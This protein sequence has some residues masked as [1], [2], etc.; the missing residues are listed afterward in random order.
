MEFQ[1]V[2]VEE[3][4]IVLPTYPAAKTE[5]LPMF[6]EFRSHQN[7]SGNPY[8]SH[9]AN[10]LERS[11]KKDRAWRLI[12]LENRYLRL[13]IMPELGGR[14]YSALDKQTGYDFFYKQHV[15]KPALIG[16]LGNWISGGL[17]FNWPYHHRPST[18]MPTDTDIE[19]AADGAITVW[20]SEHEPLGRTKGMVGIRLAPD[21]AIFDT[22]VRIY[23]RT[24]LRKS[25]LWWENAAVPV[26]PQYR[27][28]FP[29]DV[30]YVQFHYRKDIATWPIAHGMFNGNNLGENCD[31]SYHKNSHEATSYFCARSDYGYF[32]GYDEGKHCGIVHVADPTVSIG[33]K[34]FSWGYSQLSKVWE[35][36]L[37][38]ADGAY[39]ELMASSYSSDQPDFTW[40]EPYEEKTFMQSWYPIGAIGIPI[41]AARDV[42]AATDG[43]WLHLH[44]TRA[45][46]NMQLCINQKKMLSISMDP[47]QDIAIPLTEELK[48]LLILT[49]DGKALLRYM[50]TEDAPDPI[51]EKLPDIPTLDKM[52][53][54]EECYLTGVHLEQYHDPIMSPA[55][56]WREALRFDPNHSPS[57]YMLAKDAYEHFR[58]AE[59]YDYACRA[60]K[61]CTRYNFHP[62]SGRLPYLLGLICAAQAQTREARNWFLQAAWNQDARSCAMTKAAEIDGCHKNY[63]AMLTHAAMAIAAHPANWTAWAAKAVAQYH[64]G[65]HALALA[66]LEEILREDRL[67][68]LA[69]FLKRHML[70]YAHKYGA[71]TDADQNL[72]DLAEDLEDMGE[73]ALAQIA[74]T[75]MKHTHAAFAMRR[76]EAAR[77]AQRCKEYPEDA[78]AAYE[79]A[80]LL[81]AKGHWQKAADIWA[82]LPSAAAKRNL[83]VAQYSHLHMRQQAQKNLL[84]AFAMQPKNQQLAFET[85]YVLNKTGAP[86]E[87]RV[88]FADALTEMHWDDLIVERARTYNLAGQY[89]CALRLMLSH[90]FI[91]CEGGENTV[92]QQYMLALMGLA[93][94]AKRR[95]DPQ[96][97][98]KYFRQALCYPES[99]NTGAWNGALQVPVQFKLADTLAMLGETKEAENLWRAICAMGQDAILESVLPELGCYQI[100]ALRRLGHEAEA[101]RLQKRHESRVAQMQLARDSGYY[102]ATPFFISYCE[103]A[104]LQR[105]AATSWQQAMGYWAAGKM[106]EACAHAL[107]ALK[108]DPTL[109]YARFMLEEAES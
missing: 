89:Q 43:E 64:L 104:A 93:L 3:T 82:A 9:V 13:E 62:E 56:Y 41:C 76:S 4:T 17:E 12:R 96:T 51:P 69:I 18:Y 86:L 107:H 38:D 106:N 88:M 2:T 98:A 49:H 103:D 20:L 36:S 25:F 58:Y 55:A 61:S 105:S 74:L 97:A 16:M 84:D 109:Q 57:L 67:N 46:E 92:A 101:E 32:G 94:A 30:R 72:L 85:L 31:I 73:T 63:T 35:D 50:P 65:E 75:Q 5:A 48:S 68:L 34:M 7:A 70:G 52:R 26:N 37:T 80:C 40:L 39:A 11:Y 8:P 54:A 24:E 60:W 66:S 14:I 10:K 90:R 47:S 100:V 15:I 22:I 87:Q 1:K 79:Y 78:T 6:A 77:L 83:A 42:A 28:F 102:Q 19:R 29:P 33:K 53:T 81:Y 44:A 59:A 23:N 27:L 21:Q 95:N 108:Q 99:L 45:L 71:F 91:P